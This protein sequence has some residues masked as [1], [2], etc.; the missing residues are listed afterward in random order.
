MASLTDRARNKLQPALYADVENGGILDAYLNGLVSS[1]QEVED[2]AAD[3]DAGPGWSIVLDLDRAPDKFMTWLSQ[4]VGVDA[5]VPLGQTPDQLRAAISDRPNW[6]RG[7]P[8][9]I[10][11]AV[12]PFLT[13][14]KTVIIR[15]RDTSPYHFSVITYDAETL[16]VSG[17][18]KNFTLSGNEITDA[19]RAIGA[20]GDGRLNDSS[21]GIWEATTNL[22]TGNSDFETDVAGWTPVTAT[23]VQSAADK[24]FGT[25]SGLLTTTAS[26]GYILRGISI[27]GATLG[28]KY[29]FS[30]WVK[31]TA[32]EQV[33]AQITAA[34]GAAGSVFVFNDVILTGLW[35]RHSVSITLAN[36]DRTVLN[37]FASTLKPTVPQIVYLDGMQLE[38]K[39]Y[40]TPYI[41]SLATRA[42][43]RVQAP[44]TLFN[45][46]QGYITARI[47]SGV[48]FADREGARVWRWRVDANNY[49]EV[50][51][52]RRLWKI[53]RVAAGV[54]EEAAIPYDS[55][56]GDI[57]TLVAKWDKKGVAIS[58]NGKSFRAPIFWDDFE[59]ADMAN[60]L[61]TSPSGIPWFITGTGYLNTGINSGRFVLNTGPAAVYAYSE[62][63]GGI[64]RR[65][66]CKFSY[67]A[68]AGAITLICSP[69][70]LAPGVQFWSQTLH[71]I[72]STTSWSIQRYD[73]GVV[74][75]TMANGSFATPLATDGTVYEFAITCD[76]DDPNTMYVELPSA[77]SATGL[78]SVKVTNAV[79]GPCWG[80]HIIY[81]LYHGDSASRV[82]FDSVSTEIDTDVPNTGGGHVTDLSSAAQTDI[83]SD[84]AASHINSDL[85]WVAGGMGVITNDMLPSLD[86][87]ATDPTIEMLPPSSI[88]TFT[89]AAVTNAY[90]STSP[91]PR[92]TQAILSQKPAGLQFSH[93]VNR[94]QDYQALLN[95]HPLY[96]NLFADY[97]TYQGVVDDKPGS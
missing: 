91:D 38:L 3:S 82:R 96:S 79:I 80:K 29:T 94:G 23:L 43:A 37:L 67:G 45:A 51:Y 49:I 87:G 56:I 48:A 92:I 21:V 62:D 89:W 52:E 60:N 33:R 74:V 14:N 58:R 20:S 18:L 6:K 19:L 30:Y 50:L 66:S 71:C 7:T 63:I 83:G 72:C 10:S 27:T 55:S 85:F 1:L 39:G 4:F 97:A 53:R 81:E 90:L 40:A 15:E 76:P 59:R 64:A 65:M 16:V 42:A 35:Q 13:G 24:K 2:Y 22:V 26:G 5:T 57:F 77:D 73:T 25:K 95:N 46:A 17:A 11:A 28:R 78:R 44:S 31:G 61:G 8:A 93:L 68:P 86:F 12:K 84:G 70:Q 32:G 69:S 34:G 75:T 88:P 9:A 36:N 47:R 41:G 54:V